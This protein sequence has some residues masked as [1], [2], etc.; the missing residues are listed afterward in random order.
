M[1]LE[2]FVIAN[3]ASKYY[4]VLLPFLNENMEAESIIFLSSNALIKFYYRSL[5][6]LAKK[7]NSKERKQIEK[8]LGEEIN[9]L[10]FEM[11]YRLKSY[12]NRN[13]GDV[14]N[15]LIEGGNNF[16]GQ[17]LKELA[18]MPKID[19]LE[20]MSA[21]K[22][23]NIFIEYTHTHKEIRKRELELYYGEI[24]K[25]ESDI[26]YVISAMNILFISDENIDALLEVDESF[27]VE[28]AMEYLIVR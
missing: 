10:N 9:L 25:Q 28:E 24:T 26:L 15:Y 12:Y 4:R 14:F 7:F 3:K 1:D 22:Y 23:K 16:N 20:K 5:L 27:T 21:S 2:S 6:K 19:F 11:L 17:R 8:F 13:D 18:E